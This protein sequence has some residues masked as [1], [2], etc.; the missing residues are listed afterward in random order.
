MVSYSGGVQVLQVRMGRHLRTLT[1][2][3]KN[4]T[5]SKDLPLRLWLSDHA[6]RNGQASKLQVWMKSH[7]GVRFL[8]QIDSLT[9]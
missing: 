8:I 2:Y 6:T 9:V 7:H 3:G 1:D 4:P 5:G